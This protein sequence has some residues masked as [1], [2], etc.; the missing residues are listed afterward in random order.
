MLRR[1]SA[2]YLLAFAV[3]TLII[4][5][6]TVKGQDGLEPLTTS[7]SGVVAFDPQRY[8]R[9]AGLALPGPAAI[10]NVN[11]TNN[12]LAQNETTITV[13]PTN[14]NNVVGGVND[15]RSSPSGDVNCGYTRSSDG[16]L[17]WSSGIIQGVTQGNG[18]PFDYDAAGDPTV[19]YAGDGAVHF[20]CLGFDR[21]YGRSALVAVKSTDNGATW[22]TP[23]AI[24]QSNSSNTFHDKEMLTIDT[25]ASSPYYGRLYVAWTQFTGFFTTSRVYV[26]YSADGGTTWSLPILVSGSHTSVQGAH[27]AAGPD[28][29][30]YVTWCSPCSGSARIYVNKSSNGGATWGAPVQAASLTGLPSP[31]TGNLFRVNNF[32][33]AAVDQANGTIY[34]TYADYAAG[35]AD[36]MLVRST[37]QG[38][39]WS[40]PVRVNSRPQDDQF[41]QWMDVAA[42]GVIWICYYDQ[43]WNATNWLDVSCSRST[44]QGISFRRAG[45]ATTQSSNPAND[46]FGGTFIGDYNGLS[47]G[48]NNQPRALWTDTRAGNA[49]AYTANP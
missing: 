16:G 26:A 13:H 32:P 40:A 4:T 27:P 31:L 5:S 45:R 19:Y 23:V 48:S 11:T 6:G 22:T 14:V 7:V 28:G 2:L 21:T 8:A 39:T 44:N 12:T 46:G 43:S 15:Y 18:G 24:V 37:D 3:A 9:P 41:F 47:V 36:V 49:E 20:V 17:S 30:V 25:T 10:T 34:V 35:N 1:I 38:A 33:T 42:N 29:A